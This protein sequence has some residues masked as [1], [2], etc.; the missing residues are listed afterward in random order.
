MAGM[1][2][3]WL[4]DTTL[5]TIWVLK[6]CNKVS[7]TIWY[8]RMGFLWAGPHEKLIQSG[9]QTCWLV[10]PH[11]SYRSPV[12]ITPLQFLAVDVDIPPQPVFQFLKFSSWGWGLQVTGYSGFVVWV[13]EHHF[14]REC[15]MQCMMLHACCSHSSPVLLVVAPWPQE[16]SSSLLLL[17]L[18]AAKQPV[19]MVGEQDWLVT[20]CWVEE[21]LLTDLKLQH[22]WFEVSRL[23]CDWYH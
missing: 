5:H 20:S 17:C 2:K 16:A 12:V 23:R 21:T 3:Y 19:C 14:N 18:A 6:W 10:L 13:K 7:C 8:C 11:T 9:S 15:M 22:I 1:T 4:T